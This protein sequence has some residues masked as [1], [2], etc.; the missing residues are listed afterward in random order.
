MQVRTVM[1]AVLCL[2][3]CARHRD[4]LTA[5]LAEREARLEAARERADG[6]NEL[7]VDVAAL[8]ARVR[9]NATTP[10][11]SG[12]VSAALDETPVL[13]TRA[14][15]AQRPL[16]PEGALEGVE[17][18]RLRA[19]IAESEQRMAMLEPRAGAGDLRAPREP[20]R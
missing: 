5:A 4:E 9:R 6:L 3:G 1:L 8:E 18:A 7:R 10:E 12:L 15:P 19:E 17:G 11:A 13:P 2:A 16:P 14:G 20:G